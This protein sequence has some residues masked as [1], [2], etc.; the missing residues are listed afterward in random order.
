MSEK[1]SFF[2]MVFGKKEQ[3]VKQEYTSLK[4]LNSINHSFTSFTNTNLNDNDTVRAC[5]DA[6]A[7]NVAKLKPMH[8]RKLNGKILPQVSELQNKLQFSPN[9]YMDGYTFI[10]KVVAN[11]LLNNNVYI[12]VD[13]NNFYP[14]TSNNVELL[15]YQGQI[16]VKFNFINGEKVTLPYE[17]MIHLR[18]HFVNNDLFG[19]S[20]VTPLNPVLTAINSS[21]QSIVNTVESATHLRGLLKFSQSMLK[22]EDLKNQRDIFL[23]DYLSLENSSGIAALDAKADFIPLNNEAQV[24]DKA[25]M[26]YIENSIYNYFG[27]NK[28]II[29]SDY[30]EE[31]FNAF[32]SSRVEPIAIQMSLEFTRKLFTTREKSFGNEIVFSASRLTFASNETKIAMARDL[33][34]LGL[35]TVNELRE[36]FELEPVENRDVRYTTLNIVQA[37]NA[38][39]YQLGRKDTNQSEEKPIEDPIEDPIET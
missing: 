27:V 4:M 9:P 32:Y 24:I 11:L 28:S 16:Y 6:I 30:T 39:E 21:N 7:R 8:V 23:N 34:P 25:V 14:I 18:N 22:P 37:D 3:Q 2:E 29:Q 20:N 36:I 33:L 35:F 13:K 17:S 15:E 31:Q 19:E 1:R 38:N 5:I 26:E 10:Y 12:Y